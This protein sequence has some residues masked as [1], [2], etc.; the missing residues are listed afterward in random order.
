LNTKLTV[1]QF[2][3]LLGPKIEKDPKLMRIREKNNDKLT[4][5]YHDDKQMEIYNMYEGKQLGIQ[6]LAEPENPNDDE[7]LIMMQLWEPNSW[8]L[9]PIKE[10]YVEK[11]CTLTLF[12]A[13]ISSIYNIPV[14]L[15]I[16]K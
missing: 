14:F 6:M 9:S 10:I 3:E 2:K 15:F 4:K 11:S 8:S 12:S 5:V 7:L 1:K 16:I 13:L